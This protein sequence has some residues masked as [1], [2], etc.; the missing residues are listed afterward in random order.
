MHHRNGNARPRSAIMS[1]F[2]YK[3]LK[4]L[5]V[6]NIYCFICPFDTQQKQFLT[7]ES[8]KQNEN[9]FIRALDTSTTGTGVRGW[10]S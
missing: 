10:R 4:L 6:T 1:D 3:F 7:G 9:R 5:K 8:R 2:F